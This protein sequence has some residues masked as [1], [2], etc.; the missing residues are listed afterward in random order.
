VRDTAKPLKSSELKHLVTIDAPAGTLAETQTTLAT[1][2]PA[3][4]TVIS[5]QFQAREAMAHGGLMAQLFYMV[6]LRYRTDVH[7]SLVLVEE[8]CTQRRFQIQS[9]IPSDRRDAIDMMCVTSS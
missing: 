5:P 6:S 3:A 4:I 8:C 9:V 1:R 7:P 2:V